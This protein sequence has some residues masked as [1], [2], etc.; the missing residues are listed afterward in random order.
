M[1]AELD[2]EEPPDEV[3][4]LEFPELLELPVLLELTELLVVLE[5]EELPEPDSEELP[6]LAGVESMGAEDETTPDVE[7]D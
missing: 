5:T 7:P 4:L 3:V 2:E 1:L 6:E